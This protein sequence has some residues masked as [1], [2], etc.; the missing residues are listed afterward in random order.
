MKLLKSWMLAATLGLSVFACRENTPDPVVDNR[1][2][3]DQGR[4][5]LQG[6]I[7]D[8]TSLLSN[9]MYILRGLV[10]V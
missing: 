6:D 3:D 9:E 4:V 7:A 5:V 8:N 1:E 10:Y 2:K